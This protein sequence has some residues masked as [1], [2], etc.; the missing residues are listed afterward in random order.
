MKASQKLSKAAVVGAG[1]MGSGIAQKIATE[2]VDVILV[3]TTEEQ[4]QTGKK[5]I[6]TLLQEGVERGVF[7]APQVQE[8]LNRVTPS[9]DLGSLEDVDV[10]VEA[11]FEDLDIKKHLFGRLDATCRRDTILATNTSS[12]LVEDLAAS[13]AHPERV[14]GLHYFYHPAKNRLVEVVGHSTSD[15]AVLA[16]A[17]RFQERIGKTPIAS[18]DA[19]GF[20]VNR[21]FVPWLNESVR[22][23]EEGHAIATIEA[24][25]KQALGIGMG[26]FELMNVTGVPI[27]L[28]AANALAA[29]LGDFYQ[30]AASIAKQVESKQ[31]WELL[32]RVDETKFSVIQERLWGVIFH[33]SLKLASE[34]VGT[35]EDTDI[36][37]RV[38]LRWPVG[39]FEKMNAMGFAETARL[40]GLVQNAYTYRNST[41][42]P[43]AKKDAL[44]YAAGTAR[45][46]ARHGDHYHQSPRPAQRP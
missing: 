15:A 16:Q 24:A 40:C 28:H 41:V 46:D 36:G 42:C 5:R 38:G 19:P 11:V 7:A 10:V 25:A 14:I 8:I 23:H 29:K 44:F 32:G 45:C 3:D 27:T 34:K 9:G 43:T 4:A 13:T 18:A 37:A 12:F 22:L 17:W 1:N 20:V 31:S 30:A 35:L 6:A 2:G 39:P 33:I 21:F 26:P